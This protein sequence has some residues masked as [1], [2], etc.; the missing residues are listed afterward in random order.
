MTD[1]R[2][3]VNLKFVSWCKSTVTACEQPGAGGTSAYVVLFLFRNLYSHYI[4]LKWK[5][6]AG[7]LG[8]HALS[9][10]SSFLANI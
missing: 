1:I 9:M 6:H 2:Y 4:A 8:L 3:P 7:M 10:T 5:C